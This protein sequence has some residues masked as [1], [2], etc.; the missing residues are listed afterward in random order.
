MI[1][2]L[3][4]YAQVGKDTVANYLVEHYGYRRVAFAD[5]IRQALYRLSPKVDI[6][7][8]RG[9]PLAPLVDGLGWEGVK[10]DSPDVRDLLQRMGTEVGRNLF[11]EDFWV[12]QALKGISKFDKIVLTDV[13]F[14]NEYRAIKSREGVVWRVEKLGI[15]P[16]NRHISETALDEAR[17]DGII[18]NNSSK[19]DLYATLDY[20]MQHI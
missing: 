2:G 5:P 16:V 4:G 15:E 14:P 6:A 9:V 11:G 17:F 3:S 7:D 1:I 19:D 8:M 10:V 20:L 13:R 18:T 12:D